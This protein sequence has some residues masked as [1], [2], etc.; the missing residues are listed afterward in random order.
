MD[1]EPRTPVAPSRAMAQT[2]RAVSRGSAVA[3]SVAERAGDWLWV[4]LKRRPFL[5]VAFAGATGVALA[6]FVGV[7]ELGLG[8]AFAYVAYEALRKHVPPSQAVR[9]GF[10]LEK[11]LGL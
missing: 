6:T 1:N 7:A 10:K 11:E 9:E 8:V 3:E 2:S 4:R 5:G